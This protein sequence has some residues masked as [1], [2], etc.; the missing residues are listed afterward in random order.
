MALA[1][2]THFVSYGGDLSTGRLM[3]VDRTVRHRLK[4]VQDT[5]TE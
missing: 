3:A 1:G 4:S 5:V 2:R